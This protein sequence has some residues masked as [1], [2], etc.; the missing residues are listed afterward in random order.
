MNSRFYS[1]ALLVT[2][3]ILLVFGVNDWCC[4]V[5]AMT[6]RAV[7]FI[8]IGVLLIAFGGSVLCKCK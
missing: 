7:I 5:N 8:C 4:I 1:A 6:V 2:G 3:T